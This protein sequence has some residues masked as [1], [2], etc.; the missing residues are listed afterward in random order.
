[1]RK[2]LCG[3]LVTVTL[4][5]SIAQAQDAATSQPVSRQEFDDLKKDN[6]EMKKELA[7]LKKAQ[8]DQSNNSDQDAQYTQSAIQAVTA[9]V[10]K[11]KSGAEGLVIA[12]DAAFGFESQRKTESSFNADVSPLILWQPPDSKFLIETAFDLSI[13]QG[14]GSESDP[15]ENQ[16]SQLVVNLADVSYIVSNNIMVGAG[17]FAVPF[18]QYHNHFDPPWID[19]FPDEPLAFGDD[20]I[21]PTSE[22]GFYAKGAIPSGTTRWTYD[23]YVA[24]GPNLITSDSA[25]AGQLAFNDYGDLNNNKAVGGR[26]GFLPI[27]E[28]ETGYSVQTS[29]V[30]PDGAGIPNAYAL[31]QAV[32]FHYKP[33][34][35][36]LDG[37][38]DLTSE[39]IWSHVSG[40]TYDP[41]AAFGFGP[42]MLARDDR[43][44]GYVSLCYRPTKADSEIVR[45]FEFVSRYDVITSP[46][47]SPGGLHEQRETLGVDYWFTPDIALQTA[48]EIDQE[49]VGPDQDAFLVEIGVGL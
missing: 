35:D 16:N 1:M 45:N 34:I 17:L 29:R 30:N 20:A 12:G 37:Q 19:K 14:N 48:Y 43:N 46:L 15:A 5:R 10:A 13:G 24:N 7:D 28:L 2:I 33:V 9:E 26:I 42:E 22:V 27:P 6:A 21:G 38:F 25:T 23:L 41:T 3:I 39:W 49:K 44:G 32:D 40:G 31:L 36:A 4:L 47:N 8:A 18:G 11:Q